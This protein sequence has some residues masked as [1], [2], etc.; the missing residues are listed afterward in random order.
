[1]DDGEAV[2]LLDTPVMPNTRLRVLE[3]LQR[4]VAVGGLV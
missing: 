1:V 4:P 2:F 3:R